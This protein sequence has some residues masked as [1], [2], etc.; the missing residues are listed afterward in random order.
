MDAEWYLPGLSDLEKVEFLEYYNNV[1]ALTGHHNGAKSLWWY[2]WS[3]TRDRFN[4]RIRDELE[5][6]ARFKKACLEGIP[7]NLTVVCKDPYVAC[8]L[9]S[10]A[11]DFG[12]AAAVFLDFIPGGIVYEPERIPYP[13]CFLISIFFL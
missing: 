4:S 10:I 2:T 1:I 7:D 13:P 6:L 3:S 12:I 9:R 8:G 5:L 11:A